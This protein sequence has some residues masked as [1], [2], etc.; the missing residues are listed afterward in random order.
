[1]AD[2]LSRRSLIVGGTAATAGALIPLVRSLTSAE[3][4]PDGPP[5]PEL[6][7]LDVSTPAGKPRTKTATLT[8]G[9][10]GE[11]RLAY[12][13]TGPGPGPLMR[14]RDGDRVRL[15]F[16]NDLDAPSSLHVHGV[17]MPPAT[18]APLTHLAPGQS[19][20][21]EFTL[22]PGSAG[23]YWYHPHAHGDVERQLLAGLAGPVVVTGPLG[24][25]SSRPVPSR[26]R[27]SAP[28]CHTLESS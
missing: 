5:L 13:H 11:G 14:L 10:A 28:R 9:S 6:P 12:N 17:P 22:P 8:A 19:D 1:M 15:T 24:P 27:C 25:V 3:A 7:E 16:R 21:R 2:Y 18:D 4:L 23:T 20:V 26:Q